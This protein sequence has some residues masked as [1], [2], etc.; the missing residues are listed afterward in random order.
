M[1]K[2]YEG[3]I[4]SM[5]QYLPILLDRYRK[6]HPVINS[7]LASRTLFYFLESVS[8]VMSSPT[9]RLVRG[10]SRRTLVYLR[11]TQQR[12]AHGPHP[13]GARAR[14]HRRRDGDLIRPLHARGLQRDH[15]RGHIG[16]SS[17]YVMIRSPRSK[18]RLCCNH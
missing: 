11:P 10:V 2:Y 8:K 15:R 1:G 16:R 12:A 13:D 9:D 18:P 5:L 14:C 7:A 17:E 4:G 6:P 3:I